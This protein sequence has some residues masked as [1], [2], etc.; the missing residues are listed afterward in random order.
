MTRG[1]MKPPICEGC[2]DILT[3][4]YQEPCRSCLTAANKTLTEEYKKKMKLVSEE[5]KR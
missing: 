4:E 2:L 5:Q 3:S 1:G